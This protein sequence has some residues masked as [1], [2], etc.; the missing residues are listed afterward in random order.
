MTNYIN[1]DHKTGQMSIDSEYFGKIYI[2]FGKHPS[3]ITSRSEG[4]IYGG[5]A[6][7]IKEQIKALEEHKDA[8]DIHIDYDKTITINK[9]D[10]EGISFEMQKFHDGSRLCTYVRGKRKGGFY[11]DNMT[12]AA[13]DK[14]RKE[15]E[16][17]IGDDFD[18]IAS[19]ARA[20]AIA[21][22]KHTVRGSLENVKENVQ[23]AL[24][25]LGEA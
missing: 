3:S 8:L 24:D 7:F 18:H 13:R 23:S 4:L 5:G 15:I 9:V 16:R 17:I 20:F 12:E 11:H 1:T 25:Y 10:Y 21:N 6:R 14:V 22:F 2:R 19:A